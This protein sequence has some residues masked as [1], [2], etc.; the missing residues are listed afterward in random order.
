MSPRLNRVEFHDG[1]YFDLAI[2]SIKPDKW[3]P[4]GVRYRMAWI[5]DDRCRV[6]F[7]N[8]H[9]KE[10]HFHIDGQEFQYTFISVEQLARD[11]ADQV[12][13]MG[14]PQ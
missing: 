10:D 8:H 12:R 14:G 4:H 9:G 3:R 1:S 11:F 7:D 13:K 5:Q 6:L 2:D